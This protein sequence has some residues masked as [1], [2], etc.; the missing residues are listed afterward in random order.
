MSG[1]A[2][3]EKQSIR[4]ESKAND[5]KNRDG[6]VSSTRAKSGSKRSSSA[7]VGIC[8]SIQSHQPPLKKIQKST[9]S[10]CSLWQWAYVSSQTEQWEKKYF[11]NKQ[12]RQEDLN[13][14][15]NHVITLS[16]MMNLRQ[17]VKSI[18]DTCGVEVTVNEA[19][20]TLYLIK[21]DHDWRL[22]IT[23]AKDKEHVIVAHVFKSTHGRDQD[24]YDLVS[25]CRDKDQQTLQEDE[26]EAQR[27]RSYRIHNTNPSR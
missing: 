5:D 8:K 4:H 17:V 20:S 15:K 7:S 14:I 11:G 10:S 13:A 22:V 6:T 16:G 2:S 9:T 27:N 12:K 24:G 18:T 19:D 21:L 25:R 26:R 23:K 3:S 1:H